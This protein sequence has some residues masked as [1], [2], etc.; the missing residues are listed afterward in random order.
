[1]IPVRVR[2]PCPKCGEEI[3][4]NQR[5]AMRVNFEVG[6][7]NCKA[8]LHTSDLM[9]LLRRL[10]REAAEPTRRKTIKQK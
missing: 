10:A 2:M 7:P 4:L 9:N 8:I 5:M 3:L 1:M 6:C